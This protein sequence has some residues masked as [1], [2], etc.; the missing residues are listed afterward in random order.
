M[1][2]RKLLKVLAGSAG[3]AGSLPGFGQ[4][5][6]G[7]MRLVVPYAAGGLTDVMA[8]LLAQHMQQSLQRT[9]IVENKA[10]AAG[11][12]GTRQVVQSAPD[13]DTLLLHNTGVIAVQMLQRAAGYDALVDLSPVAHVADGPSFLM[14]HESIPARTIPEFLAFA[15]TIPQGIDCGNSGINSSGH[16]SAM[17]VEKLGRFKAV[18]VPFKGSAEVTQALITGQVKMQVSVT[19]EALNPH[20]KSGRIRL[21]GVTSDRR[22]ALAPEVPPIK[23]FLPEFRVDSWYGILAPGKTPMARR[24]QIA[25]SIRDALADNTLRERYMA[26]YMEPAY[27][28]PA[29]FGDI[30]KRSVAH[31]KH[32]IEFLDLKP[33]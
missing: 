11:A 18:H 9:I 12:L 23:D 32:T 19:T 10:G 2:R 6:Q 20:I 33:A 15:R 28:P 17:L 5:Q 7:L 13:G 27:R 25:A 3:V 8:R 1:N 30:V 24:E 16:V 26:M 29:E 21:L 14:V 22:S 4:Q 31:W